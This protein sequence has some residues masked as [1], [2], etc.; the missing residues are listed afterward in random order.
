MAGSLTMQCALLSML[1]QPLLVSAI[2]QY[3]CHQWLTSPR[4]SGHSSSKQLQLQP[5]MLQ[6]VS[7]A[8]LLS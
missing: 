2:S 7:L 1:A 8:L 5:W 3:H 6:W 4:A